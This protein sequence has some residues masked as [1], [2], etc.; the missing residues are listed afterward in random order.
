M[1]V[2]Y[3]VFSLEVEYLLL[4]S[5]VLHVLR[6]LSLIRFKSS[7][8]VDLIVVQVIEVIHEVS[9]VICLLH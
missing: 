8:L 3:L 9:F 1:W 6:F 7:T 4:S 2:D 5:S